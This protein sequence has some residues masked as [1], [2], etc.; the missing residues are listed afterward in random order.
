MLVDIEKNSGCFHLNCQSNQ[1]MRSKLESTIQDLRMNTICE[2]TETSLKHND[3]EELWHLRGE[4][5]G[6]FRVDRRSSQYNKI[7]GVMFLISKKPN[8]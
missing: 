2:F 7:G 5:F 3:G 6:Y 1:R 8:P 4:N